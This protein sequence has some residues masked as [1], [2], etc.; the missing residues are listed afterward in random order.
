M[1]SIH[2]PLKD[3]GSCVTIG[4]TDAFAKVLNLLNGDSVFFDEYAYGTAVSACRAF[5]RTGLGVEMDAQG[6]IPE[7]LKRQTLAAREK[8]FDPDLVYLVP[9]AQNPTGISMSVARKEEIYRV[10]QDLDLYIVEDDA[11]FYLYHGTDYEVTSSFDASTL[12]GL[13]KLPM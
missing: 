2:S 7:D 13:R 12:P 4:S 1:N 6:M 3:F 9:V 8:G 5:G 11:Y 10:C